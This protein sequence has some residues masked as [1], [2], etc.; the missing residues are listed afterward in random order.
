MESPYSSDYESGSEQTDTEGLESASG[1]G[2]GSGSESGSDSEFGGEYGARG[3]KRATLFKQ[4]PSSLESLVDTHF[5]IEAEDA[6]KAK[7]SFQDAYKIV[8]GIML[9]SELS[10]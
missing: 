5:V 3:T 7:M 6:A 9:R 10:T 1:S 8:R 2:S 4:Q